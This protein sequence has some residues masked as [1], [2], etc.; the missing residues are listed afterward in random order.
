MGTYPDFD[1][2][3]MG[4]FGRKCLYLLSRATGKTN[5]G[6]A[7]R[8]TAR[9]LVSPSSTIL[10]W[11]QEVGRFLMRN[12]KQVRFPC[13]LLQSKQSP[14]RGFLLRWDHK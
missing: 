8:E 5:H 2:R 3:I 11:R 14:F 13:V 12:V 1:L 4:F 9:V 10:F 6:R 7:D